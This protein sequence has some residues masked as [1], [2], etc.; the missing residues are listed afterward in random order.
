MDREKGE[1]A[2]NP[3]YAVG[4]LMLAYLLAMLDRTILPMMIEPVQHDLWISD[5]QFGLLQGFAFAIFYCVAG[6]PL[7]WMIDRASRR[8]IIALGIAGWS[9]MTMLSGRAPSFLY[10]FLARIGVGVGE[11]TL[12]PAAYS[13]MADMFPREKLTRAVGIFTSGAMAGT[14]LAFLFG[15][16]LVSALATRPTITL[17]L[18]G[19]TRPWQIAFLGAGAP[20]LIL[21]LLMLTVREPRRP[22]QR[23]VNSGSLTDLMTFL[24]NQWKLLALH[25]AGF[26]CLSIVLYGFMTWVPALFLRVY[27][28]KASFVG[29]AMGLAI[30]VFG[31][32]GLV[33]GSALAD[34]WIRLGHADSHMRVGLVGMM[35]G[36]PF[37]LTLSL[38]GKPALGLA[39]L[40]GLFLC[41]LLPSAAGP[42]GLQ[43]VTPPLLRGRI[44]S[45]FMMV[46]NLLGL[47]LGPLIVAL[48]TDHVFHN[49]LAVGHSLC[50]LTLVVMPIAIA[51]FGMARR[52]F[53]EAFLR[54]NPDDVAQAS[55]VA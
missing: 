5:T 27:G 37:A 55:K 48:F 47:G 18:L 42:A 26:S 45:L 35:A 24:R 29:A 4:L 1:R 33:G 38:S 41:L 39:S 53:A 16:A 3:W 22:L 36:I 19:P 2:G 20:G 9:L 6:I 54:Q 7:G 31:I 46:I 23:T 17:P 25:F 32:A 51:V 21:A 43:L 44:S 30:S 28:L 13:M 14:G 52:P 10:L 34:R 15:G 8:T 49:R 12:N 40:C 11:A 50:G